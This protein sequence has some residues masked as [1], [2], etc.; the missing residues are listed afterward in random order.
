MCGLGFLDGGD[1]A[2][3]LSQQN[4]SAGPN[5][6]YEPLDS[7]AS[8]ETPAILTPPMDDH[9]QNL[10]PRSAPV[11]LVTKVPTM[12]FT[13]ASDLHPLLCPFGE[14][15]QLKV[16]NRPTDLDSLSVTVEYKTMAQAR[17]ARASL[18]GQFYADRCLKVEFLLPDLP[19][20]VNSEFSAWSTTTS[21]GKTGLN[22]F[23]TPFQV[24]LGAPGASSSAFSPFKYNV[25]GCYASDEELSLSR[26]WSGCSTPLLA[27]SAQQSRDQTGSR[28]FVPS[29]AS[30]RPRSAPSQ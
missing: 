24:H 3:V 30:S 27:F 12:L 17:E 19:S 1:R 18:D 15:V 29:L 25:T 11:L 22:P 28:L 8:P 20:P 16:L 14:I 23:A 5:V 2:M 4:N 6:D 21:E 26:D 10:A 13:H 7:I 9:L